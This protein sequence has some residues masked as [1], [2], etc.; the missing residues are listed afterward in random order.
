MA[1]AVAAIAA[2][3]N[4]MLVWLLGLE[5]AFNELKRA[6]PVECDDDGG[7]GGGGSE[8]GREVDDCGPLFLCDGVVKL[9]KRLAYFFELRACS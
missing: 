1:V 4:E 5:F 3:I 6:R 9:A 2:A 8:I 7:G